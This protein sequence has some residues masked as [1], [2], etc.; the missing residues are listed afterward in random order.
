MSIIGH[1][2]TE[3]KSLQEENERLKQERQK[4]IEMIDKRI[5]ELENETKETS[6]EWW[7]IKIIKELQDLKKRIE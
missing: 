3:I 4:T 2:D 1:Q 6:E 7:H 5:E